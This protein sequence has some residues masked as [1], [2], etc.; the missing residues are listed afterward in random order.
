V[1]PWPR[2]GSGAGQLILMAATLHAMRAHRAAV[3]RLVA[4]QDGWQV[5]SCLARPPV[6]GVNRY[7]DP[8]GSLVLGELPWKSVPLKNSTS[9][10]SIRTARTAW[11][12][13]PAVPKRVGD[14]LGPCFHRGL[15]PDV[16]QSHDDA[17]GRC[18]RALRDLP[19]LTRGA[20]DAVAWR[21]EA[22][23][24]SWPDRGLRR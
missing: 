8:S 23:A 22:G 19:R 13:E 11:P 15:V 5:A 10:G 12:V 3:M 14:A 9:P 16:A 2:Q 1:C 20:D 4:V 24:L 7:P 18:R 17:V 6:A 21:R